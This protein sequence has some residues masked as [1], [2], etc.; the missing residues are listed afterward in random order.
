MK[1]E[2]HILYGE[3]GVERALDIRSSEQVTRLD[4]NVGIAAP[5][6]V[7]AVIQHFEESAVHFEGDP[8]A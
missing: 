8:F 6:F 1:I 2:T 4:T 5:G 3:A 7:M